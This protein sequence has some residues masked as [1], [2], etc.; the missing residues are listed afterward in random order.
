MASVFWVAGGILAFFLPYIH[1]VVLA[2]VIKGSAMGFVS[3]SVPVYICEAVAS[4]KKGQSLSFMHLCSA[5]GSLLIFLCGSLFRKHFHDEKSFK[6]TWMC[7]SVWGVL[8]LLFSFF[9]PE[10]PKWLAQK[11]NWLQAAK[12]LERLQPQKKGA[13][14]NFAPK[15]RAEEAI[16][17]R[18]YTGG[19]NAMRR[20]SYAQLFK[21]EL[22]RLTFTAILTQF[23]VQLSCVGGLMYYFVDICSHCGVKLH[24]IQWFV[25][26]QYGVSALFTLFPFAILDW[27]Q[28]KDC[29]TFG[30]LLLAGTFSGLFGV[31]RAYGTPDFS[32]RSVLS[33]EVSGVAA[34]AVLALF[35]FALSVY[36]SVVFSVSWLYSVELFPAPARAKGAS[37]AMATAWTVNTCVT[38]GLPFV[39]DKFQEWSFL[40]LGVVC[41]FSGLLFA[42]FPETRD[43]V[44]FLVIPDFAVA[45]ASPDSE[46]APHQRIPTLELFPA[47]RDF[48]KSGFRDFYDLGFQNF[49]PLYKSTAPTT[50]FSPDS[51]DSLASQITVHQRKRGF[52]RN[53]LNTLTGQ[54]VTAKT[55]FS[56]PFSGTAFLDARSP[57]S[58]STFS[59][60]WTESPQ[61]PANF[62]HT[63][64]NHL[65]PL[66]LETHL[67]SWGDKAAYPR[68]K[69]H[70]LNANR[71]SGSEPPSS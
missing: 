53:A 38:F 8:L 22:V 59:G 58:S 41:L 7:E 26:V 34:S 19:Q 31:I 10:L 67:C 71:N 56:Y 33:V 24:H 61:T 43:G 60:L 70:P 51:A 1:L 14:T 11:G 39:L 2:R 44:H 65:F 25:L 68:P 48:P 3:T 40:G 18:A 12:N 16:L 35:L 15:A 20:Y 13:N 46:L 36:A 17:L 37:I 4:N 29:L 54:L 28:R 64:H 47:S 42:T 6:Y 63:A 52:V 62:Q 45:I 9:L 27:C 32:Y 49:V 23:L 5:V 57:E 50:S 30:M 66:P 21:K 55:H 69:P